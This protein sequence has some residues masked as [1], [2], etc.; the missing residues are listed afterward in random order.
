MDR[1]EARNEQRLRD[2]P[3]MHELV[4]R[5]MDDDEAA[6]RERL[7]Q[8]GRILAA[9]MLDPSVQLKA[10]EIAIKTGMTPARVQTILMSEE[11]DQIVGPAIKKMAAAFIARQLDTLHEIAT[12]E[13]ST[14][15]DKVRAHSAMVTTY[16]V[17][18]ESDG[19]HDR[20][21]AP[22][23][24]SSILERARARRIELA[25]GPEKKT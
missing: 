17:M 10:N 18:A 25:S 6:R 1:I 20:H 14:N 23:A 13:H 15:A 2:R 11:F 12:G 8:A 9:V 3:L 5:G 7:I 16:K 22:A 21:N 19:D 4:N 24:V